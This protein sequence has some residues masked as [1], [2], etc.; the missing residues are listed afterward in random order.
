MMNLRVL[1]QIVTNREGAINSS[2]ISAGR[3]YARLIQVPPVGSAPG[4]G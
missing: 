1:L 2:G 3:V 4:S